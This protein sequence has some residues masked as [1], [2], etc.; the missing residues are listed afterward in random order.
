MKPKALSLTSLLA[1]CALAAGCAT[2][3]A[4]VRDD[5]LAPLEAALTPEPEDS[6]QRAS[7]GD[8]GAQLTYAIILEHGL[9][10][11]EA[12]VGAARHYRR[13]AMASR[14]S[15]PVTQ[16]TAAFDGQPSRINLI[17]VPVGGVG[18]AQLSAIDR[19]LADL[20]AGR[21]E[22]CG[23]GDRAD[24]IRALWLASGVR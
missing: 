12:N 17:H 16:Y 2:L 3:G 20:K 21:G 4:D 6:A 22:E 14:G 19:C 7:D 15:T 5:F 24:R 9:H 18:P 11:V 10:G 13:E 8:P 23:D 1:S